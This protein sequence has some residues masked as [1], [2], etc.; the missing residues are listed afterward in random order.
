M[1]HTDPIADLLT[2]IRNALLVQKKSVS[3]PH[4]KIK[5]E[6]VKIFK[7]EGFIKDFKVNQSMFP[8]AID[9]ELKYLPGKKPV[10]EGL[11][12]ISKPGLRVYAP[13]DDI[14][15]VLDGLGVA[16]LSTHKGILTG[17]EC[18]KRNVGGEVLLHIW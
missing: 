5:V 14:P 7:Q 12:R 13:V 2:R 8:A 18:K 17:K 16:L 4:S 1:N 15:K 6:I 11:K 10:I 3:V 9:V